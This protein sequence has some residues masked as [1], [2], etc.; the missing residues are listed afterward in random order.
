[1]KEMNTEDFGCQDGEGDKTKRRQIEIKGVRRKKRG[2]EREK[3]MVGFK[4]KEHR[5]VRKAGVTL[6]SF[7][8]KLLQ[9]PPL[10]L[11]VSTQLQ[12]IRCH[13]NR[14]KAPS[15]L[16][17]ASCITPLLPPPSPPSSILH[18]AAHYSI[19]RAQHP[20]RTN[21]LHKRR[22]SQRARPVVLFLSSP[23][24]LIIAKSSIPSSL[25]PQSLPDT[26]A[27][28]GRALGEYKLNCLKPD[29]RQKLLVY[30]GGI[31]PSYN[32]VVRFFFMPACVLT[33][34]L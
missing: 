8:P 20:R 6:L 29:R 19:Q 7:I 30:S 24:G 26:D 5:Q 15:C 34:L 22:R 1:M 27:S 3:V 28:G 10:V 31:D 33:P 25:H 17:L 9:D 11:I 21:H 16:H 32:A 12:G 14:G 13:R 23:V 2:R 4:K 18:S